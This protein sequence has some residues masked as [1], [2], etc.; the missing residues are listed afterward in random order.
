MWVCVGGGGEGEEGG[1]SEMLRDKTHPSARLPACLPAC[2]PHTAVGMCGTVG[3]GGRGRDGRFGPN[4]LPACHH[5]SCSSRVLPFLLPSYLRHPCPSISAHLHSTPLSHT[6]TRPRHKACIARPVSASPASFY[7]LHT[8]THM[9]PRHKACVD[10]VRDKIDADAAGVMA[11]ML[12]AARP[13]E[14]K[15]GGW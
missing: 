2:L 6:H 9:R 14:L 7:P 8:H 1:R 10:M 15:V 11:A 13:F 5:C 3:V 4:C 12:T